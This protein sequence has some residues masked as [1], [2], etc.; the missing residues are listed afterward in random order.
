M[1]PLLAR[2]LKKALGG[3][4][5]A[6]P[7]TGPW[8]DFI[9]A[10]D[11]AY[12]AAEADRQLT[13][14]SLELASQ[15]LQ[16]RNQELLG[17]NRDLESAQKALQQSHADLEKRVAERTLEL[18]SA[19]RQADS[20]NQAKS[21]FVA[22]MSHEIRTPLN[23]VMGMIDLLQE[24]PLS[25]VQKRYIQLAREA[26]GALMQV[27]ND[28]LDFSKIEAGK[29]EL[30]PVEFDLHK[31]VND[32]IELLTPVATKKNLSL[33][34]TICSDVPQMI[35]A[36]AGRLR[37]V[38]MNLICNALKFT[39]RGSVRVILALEKELERGYTIRVEVRD[40]GTGI[41]AD[42][43][44]RLFKSFSQVD[45]STTRRFGGTGLGLAIC[46][47]LVE[48]MA[49]EIGVN[50]IVDHG[51]TFWFTVQVGKAVCTSPPM[52]ENP[53]RAQSRGPSLAG[54]HLLVAEDNE[55]NQI[56]TEELLKL[57]GCTCEI[58]ADGEQAVEAFKKN[59]YDMVLMDWQMPRMDGLEAT[60]LIREHEA[61]AATG[62]TPIIA[63]TAGAIA[64]DREKCLAGGMD[65]YLTKPLNC[66][67]LA[68]TL[69]S[70]LGR[71][72]VETRD[73]AA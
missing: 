3:A 22:R 31:L 66:E 2:Q 55:L 8:R 67:A 34:F 59:R 20:A 5:D 49:G 47:R 33:W 25:E 53:P 46:K 58:V 52:P 14:H 40:T 61:A 29:F 43:L 30:E 32:L 73:C 65:W 35:L 44:D 16:D 56:V 12:R 17:K 13:E 57:L 7:T 37:Q 19:V 68:A 28:I 69:E 71:T 10:V 51:T 60:A 23:G 9:D 70:A 4:A 38:L 63:L 27:I 45:T 48:L 24:S 1:H 62:H 6:V 64:G 42:R 54:L 39:E 36:D 18:R 26:A 50:S 72:A 11:E 21:E 15:E 41:P